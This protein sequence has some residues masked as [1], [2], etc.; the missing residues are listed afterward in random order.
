PRPP[1]PTMHLSLTARKGYRWLRIPSPAARPRSP[2]LRRPSQ[3]HITMRTPFTALLV[4]PVG[5]LVLALAAGCSRADRP[6]ADARA[7]PAPEPPAK[8]TGE[9]TGPDFRDRVSERDDPDNPFRP[10]SQPKP[11]PA[12]VRESFDQAAPGK[13]PDGWV[14]WGSGGS[15]FAVSAG[16]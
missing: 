9:A 12:E 16:K 5:C 13:L 10:V 11:S 3:E 6:G 1:R 4:G 14:Q 15:S 2:G 7:A 8:D